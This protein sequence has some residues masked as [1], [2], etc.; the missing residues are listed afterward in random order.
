MSRPMSSEPNHAKFE[1]KVDI[2]SVALLVFAFFVGIGVGVSLTHRYSA[3]KVGES[4]LYRIDHLTGS[5]SLCR[6]VSG[7]IPKCEN[8][9]TN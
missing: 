2:R 7:A 6:V 1:W 4:A 5:V 3:Y 9:Q 8:A